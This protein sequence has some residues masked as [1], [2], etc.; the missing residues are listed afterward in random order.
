M[1]WRIMAAALALGLSEPTF[2]VVP[3]EQLR[4]PV[5]EARARIISQQL[6]CVVCQNQSIDDSDASLAHDLR[7]IVRERLSAGAS[8]KQT[9]QYLVDRYGS[10]VLLKPP[11]ETATYALWF[12]P[13]LFLLL[14]GLGAWAYVGRRGHGTDDFALNEEE[15]AR[16][17]ALLRGDRPR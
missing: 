12:G 7:V 13:A 8:D 15:A 11:V 9:I 16:V 14:G 10:Y 4:D 17:E 2:A 5:L 3:S 1:N 6:R